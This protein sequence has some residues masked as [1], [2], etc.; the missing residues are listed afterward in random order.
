MKKK[1]LEKSGNKDW[2][3]SKN[4]KK[5][6][7]KIDNNLIKEH[8][9]ELKLNINEIIEYL[10][11]TI[12]NSKMLI[13]GP[14]GSG[15]TSILKTYF[16]NNDKTSNEDMI[17]ISLAHYSYKYNDTKNEISQIEE[18]NIIEEEIIASLISQINYKNIP[19]WSK[20]RIKKKK[21]GLKE[22]QLKRIAFKFDSNISNFSKLIQ[23]Q[24][25]LI[26]ILKNSDKKIIIFED[27][28]RLRSYEII[29]KLSHINNL[30]KNYGYYMK[31]LFVLKEGIFENSIDKN[32]FFD[33]SLSIVPFI[34]KSNSY[35][36]FI[37]LIE[38]SNEISYSILKEFSGYILDNR[39]VISISNDF[40][41]YKKNSKNKNLNYDVLFILMIFKNVFPDDF[42]NILEKKK[43]I[44]NSDSDKNI[45]DK[46][47]ELFIKL[48]NILTKYPIEELVIYISDYFVGKNDKNLL[49]YLNFNENKI[50]T[51]EEE[52]ENFDFVIDF[53]DSYETQIE[54]KELKIKE[55]K[56]KM[57]NQDE[58]I[59]NELQN[60]IS[61]LE[62]KRINK[63]LFNH[64][65]WKMATSDYISEKEENAFFIML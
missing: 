27:L 36:K 20:Y 22:I 4:C 56:S 19:R 60:E 39:L 47:I 64:L 54:N 33:S 57:T 63:S 45:S 30:L 6:N 48:K 32:K 11:K 16:L 29:T 53:L 50:Y 24:Y 55:I 28:D 59:N 23:E 31:F 35:Y 13:T 5:E 52:I 17:W 12:E 2:K 14:Y 44:F 1:L 25:E 41:T 8:A 62:I 7:N 10:Q 46:N 49:N 34:N 51:D 40:N 37:Q 61:E 38:N 3:G 9:E 21:K 42:N 26:Y 65:I 58:Q 18:E 15:K 43:N